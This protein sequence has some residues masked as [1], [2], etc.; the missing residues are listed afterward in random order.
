MLHNT[1]LCPVCQ[2][3]S[4][5]CVCAFV[6]TFCVTVC[7]F[8][9]DLRCVDLR[10]KLMFLIRNRKSNGYCFKSFACGSVL[11]ACAPL[12]PLLLVSL[13]DISRSNEQ[14]LGDVIEQSSKP[15]RSHV[16]SNAGHEHGSL[17]VSIN[18]PRHDTCSFW[19]FWRKQ[20]SVQ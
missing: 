6:S 4:Q 16:V 10:R 7:V 19:D 5:V 17:C 12:G 2:I 8:L 1:E 9:R 3:M 11:A 13:S 20:S 18:C 15:P 14:F